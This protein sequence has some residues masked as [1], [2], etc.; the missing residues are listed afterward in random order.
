MN[1]YTLT[2][3]LVVLFIILVLGIACTLPKQSASLALAMQEW[4]YLCLQSQEQAFSQKQTRQVSFYPTSACFGDL[5]LEYPAGIACTPY[6]M[7]YN[8]KGN[9]NKAGT[10]TCTSGNTTASLKF[11]L[12]SGRIVYEVQ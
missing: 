7:S 5:C 8:A 11:Q 2:E 12:G 1:G 10:L 9:I 4:M 3:S 6:S